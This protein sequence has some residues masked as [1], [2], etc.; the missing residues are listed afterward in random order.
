MPQNQ[1]GALQQLAQVQGQALAQMPDPLLLVR[2]FISL[3]HSV[4]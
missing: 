4:Q 2:A 3:Q 1:L